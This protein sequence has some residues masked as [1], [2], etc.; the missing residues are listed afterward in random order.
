MARY[1]YDVQATTWHSA[2]VRYILVI[3][4]YYFLRGV[5]TVL[6]LMIAF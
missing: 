3:I 2:L 5:G 4:A 1:G 6:L